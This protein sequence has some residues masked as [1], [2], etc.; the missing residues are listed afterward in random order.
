M[1]AVGMVA[2]ATIPTAKKTN[3]HE[4]KKTIYTKDLTLPFFSQ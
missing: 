4:T 2:I 1:L 3:Y